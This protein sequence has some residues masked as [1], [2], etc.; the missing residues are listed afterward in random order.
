[1][2]GISFPELL[3]IACVGFVLIKPTDLPTI[4]KYYKLISKKL[5]VVKN[6]AT[7]MLGTF[8]DMFNEADEPE[9]KMIKG[10]DG[11]FYE[12]FDISELKLPKKRKR[13]P[14]SKAKEV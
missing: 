1:M 14:R 6:E 3:I 8:H 2:F 13:A 5:L 9:H 4:S 10:D 12:A 11:K 7:K